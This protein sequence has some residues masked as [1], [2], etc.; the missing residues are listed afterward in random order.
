MRLMTIFRA[1]TTATILIALPTLAGADVLVQYELA[2]Q[3]GTQASNPAT[4]AA[5]GIT[6]ADLVRGPGLTGNAGANSMNT[7]GW[8]TAADDY[9]RFGFTV[10]SGAGFTITDLVIATRSSAT[11][12]GLMNVLY[13]VDGGA[14]TLL[15]TLTQPNALFLDAALTLPSV[16]VSSSFAIILRAANNTAANGSPIGTAGTFR[17]GDYSPDGGATFQPITISGRPRAVPEPAG[18]VMLGIGLAAL[19]VIVRPSIAARLA[20]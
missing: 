1:F 12:P 17:V 3:P 15:T 11:G 7:A 18:F 4:F 10:T 6:G 16:A 13:S 20:A 8:S 9:I 2:G 19:V 14:E 5:A